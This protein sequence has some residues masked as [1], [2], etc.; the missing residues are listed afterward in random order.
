MIMIIYVEQ[1]TA[2]KALHNNIYCMVQPIYDFIY[3]GG[4]LLF[5]EA[6]RPG[7]MEDPFA[8]MMEDFCHIAY[9]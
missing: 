2:P 4:L 3:D 1:S 8:H 6:E 5:T 7:W 9:H